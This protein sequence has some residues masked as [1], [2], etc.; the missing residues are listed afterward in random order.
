MHYYNNQNIIGKFTRLPYSYLN[1]P[2]IQANIVNQKRKS[3]IKK[4]FFSQVIYYNILLV[5]SIFF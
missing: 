4:Y 2:A 1:A 5:L 3:K